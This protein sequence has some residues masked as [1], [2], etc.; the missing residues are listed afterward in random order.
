[1]ENIHGIQLS[2]AQAM[3]ERLEHILKTQGQNAYNAILS[4]IRAAKSLLAQHN[5]YKRTDGGLGGIGVEHWILQNDG[6]LEMALKSFASVAYQG[7]YHVEG[8]PLSLQ[9]FQKAYPIYDTGYNWKNGTIDN[10]I[11]KLTEESYHKLLD[12]CNTWIVNHP[13]KEH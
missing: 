11:L 13:D 8:K 6:S 1:M 10:Y 9:D 2:S 5:I 12:I 7:A 3:K 4:N